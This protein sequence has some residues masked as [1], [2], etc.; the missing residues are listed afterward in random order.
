MRKVFLLI[1]PLLILLMLALPAQ[2]QSGSLIYHDEV[3]NL[4]RNAIE[5][6]ARPLIRRGAKVAIY[7]VDTGRQEDFRGRLVQDG[8]SIGSRIDSD[9]I[10]IYVSFT[11][12]YSEVFSG[13]RWEAALDGRYEQIRS[14]QLNPELPSDPTRGYVNALEAIERAIANPQ[15]SGSGTTINVG[16]GTFLPIVLGVIFLALLFV[17]G[18]IAWNSYKK[19]RAAAQA[20]AAAQQAFEEARRK[21]GAAIADTGQ[22]IHHA[23]AKAEYDKHSYAASDIQQLAQ[24][25]TSAERQFVKAQEQFDAVEESMTAKPKPAESDYNAA[26]RAYEQV[27]SLVA[28]VQEQIAQVEARRAELDKLNAAAPGEIDQAKKALADVAE[29]LSALDQDF[30]RP[31]AI[32]QPPEDL[33]GQAESLLTEHRAADAIASARA[34]SATLD[35]LSQTLARYADIREGISAGRAGAENAAGQGY[36]VEAGLSA[37]EAAEAHLKQAAAALTQGGASAAAPLLDQAEAARAEGVARG[38]G[39]PA[40]RRENE[41]RLEQLRQ[42]GEQLDDYITE[43]RRTFDIVDE[44]AESTWSDI[45]GNGSEAQNAAAQARQLWERAAQ[46]NTMEQQDF[47]GAK[48]DLDVADQQIA[49]ARTLIDT[50]IQR[51][52]DLE[53]ARDAARQEIAAAQKDLDKG[54]DFIGS[55]NPDIGTVPEDMINRAAALLAQVNAELS[56]PRPDWLMIVRQAQEANHLADQALENARSEV[57]VMQKLREQVTRAQQLATAEVQK[58]IQFVGLHSDDIESSGEQ[59][60]QRLQADVQTAYRTL[61]AA[62][63]TEDQER[64]AVLRQA[65]DR[66]TALQDHAAQLYASIYAAFQRIEEMRRRV[67]AEA[68]QAERAIARAQ[69]LQ[70]HYGSYIQL[71]SAGKQKLSEARE[72]LGTIGAIR[73]EHDMQRG[74]QK[75]VEARRLAEQ[76]EQIFRQQADVL[77]HP[78]NNDAS[79]E[80]LAGML[81]GALINSGGVHHRSRNWGSGGGGSWGSSG[82]SWGDGSGSG[83]SW[84][85]GS[86]SGGSWGGGSGSGGGW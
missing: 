78:R 8:L 4:D 68:E 3:G 47:L 63:Q 6:A 5:Q 52:K 82:G 72:L 7:S 77:D 30:E 19:R 51:L 27:A 73:D 58:I 76:S 43:G 85:G 86:G 59:Q 56:S 24:A 11:T 15:S 23:R 50:I 37:F 71:H 12:R 1:G 57:E 44:F 16:S 36:R 45:R 26:A 39:M 13:D 54:R 75:A 33:I 38:G 70:Q 69:Q 10:A 53:A 35:Q 84:G 48:Q 41:Q 29:R 28:A 20:F 81:I 17:G 80:M 60:L 67:T 18:P 14:S 2:A 22:Q 55:N 64:A 31:Q 79:G 25:Q 74:L 34:A 21:A 65:L 62:D 42:A 32:M 46:R 66:Y 61:Q 40:L 49:F 9:L 83:G